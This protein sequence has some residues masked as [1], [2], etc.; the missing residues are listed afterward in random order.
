MKEYVWPITRDG[1]EDYYDLMLNC[2]KCKYCQ[3][4]FPLSST[5]DERFAGQCPSGEHWRFDTYYASGRLEL[6]RGILEGSLKW[7][8]KSR[9]IL[10]SCSMCGACEE[11][12]RTTQRLTPFKIIRKMRERYVQDGQPLLPAHQA[13]LENMR[14][15]HNPHGPSPKTPTALAKGKGATPDAEILIYEGCSQ[16]FHGTEGGRALARILDTLGV[17]YRILGQAERCCAAALFHLGH[18][19]EGSCQLQQSIQSIE[20]TGVKT[21]LFVDPLCYAT[22]RK[23]ELFGIPSPSF[24]MQHVTEYLLPL[25]E[26]R[27]AQLKPVNKKVAY[28]DSAFLA[29]HLRIYE[30]PRAILRLIPGIELKEFFRNRLNTYTP[31]G[32]PLARLAYPEMAAQAAQARLGEAQAVGATCVI[33]NDP[34][35]YASLAECKIPGMEVEDLWE[36]V[37]ESLEGTK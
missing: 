3:T 16:R 1:L 5:L 10:Y 35:E 28:Q 24:K 25:L 6:A 33:C 34:H 12:C 31:G 11:G 9:E 23:H 13:V 26:A 7:N 20:E 8:E 37:A 36:L 2:A 27:K 30:E 29:R 21:V 17:K 19:E 14:K 18:L 22:F 4:V 32:E 15:H